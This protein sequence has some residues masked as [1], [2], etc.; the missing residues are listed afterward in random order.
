VAAVEKYD[1]KS[2]P[3]VVGNNS[4]NTIMIF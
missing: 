3:A 4:F 2:E 1:S